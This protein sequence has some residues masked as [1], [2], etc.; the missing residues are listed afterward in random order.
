M[1]EASR[2]SV[3]VEV[4]VDVVVI[5]SGIAGLTFALRAAEFASVL[6]ITKKNRAASNTNYARGGIAA[7]M[8]G[9]DEA[10]M[11][12]SDTFLAGAGL[13][14]RR[15]VDLVVREGPERV[16]DLIAWGTRFDRDDDASLSLGRE[17]GHSQRRIVHAGDRTG[18]AIESALLRAAEGS[19]RLH[20]VEDLLAIDLR[21]ERRA[22]HHPRC[23]GVVALDALGRR[24]EIDAGA[25]FLATG[26][27]GQIYRNTTNPAIATGDGVAMAYR[28]GAEV[29]NLEFVQFHPTALFPTGDPAFLISEAVRG[30]GAVLRTLDGDEVMRGLHPAGSLAPRDHVARGIDG[31]LRE[32]GG[33]HVMLDCS[34]ISEAL[35]ARTFPAA[36]K[37]CRDEGIDPFSG[38]IPVVPAAHYACGGVAT[39]V[40]GRSSLPGLFAAGEVAC[41]GL[42]GANRLASNS[43]L[44]AVVVSS[45]SARVLRAD[46]RA[47]DRGGRLPDPTI[48]AGSWDRD[49][50]DLTLREEVRDLMWRDA[51]ILRRREGLEAAAAQLARLEAHAGDTPSAVETRNLITVACLVVAS[52]LQRKESRGL[53]H[54]EGYPWRDNERGLRDTRLIWSEA[55]PLPVRDP[56]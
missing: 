42:H 49:E 22:G 54:L 4:E 24:V 21:V 15:V 37:R 14:H 56:G 5:G 12:A 6:L 28:A 2:T 25:T 9:R 52:A 53:H 31:V 32:G 13:C 39:D 16:R 45:R 26:G 55:G 48:W 10:A 30:E 34:P 33:T 8:S 3:A 11:H 46:R 7:V 40:D 38:G 17:G 44:E 43:L 27:F 1:K 50:S 18:R 19:E 23:S 20:I 47:W 35:F 29:M 41:T 36:F 51:G